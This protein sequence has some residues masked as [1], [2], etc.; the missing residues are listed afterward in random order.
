MPTV[1]DL[2]RCRSSR[3]WIVAGKP[4]DD[5]ERR[6][7]RE[8]IVR[9]EIKQIQSWIGAYLVKDILR[10]AKPFMNFQYIIFAQ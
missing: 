2:N 5:G 10:R 1:E 3:G 7:W 9:L 8:F 4:E 6:K